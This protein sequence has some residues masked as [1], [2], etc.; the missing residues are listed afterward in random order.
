MDIRAI[1]VDDPEIKPNWEGANDL[2]NVG[3]KSL[4]MKKL[5]ATLDN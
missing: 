4:F 5:S 1:V 3:F 2:N